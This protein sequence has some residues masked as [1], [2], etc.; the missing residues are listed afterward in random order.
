MAS[1]CFIMISKRAYREVGTWETFKSQVTED[2][3]LAKAVKAKGLK[4]GLM[5]GGDLVRTRP[6]QTL[7]EVCRF[8]ERPTIGHWNEHFQKW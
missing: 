5:R 1:G 3:A 7:S 2:V 8:W 4:L 6:F